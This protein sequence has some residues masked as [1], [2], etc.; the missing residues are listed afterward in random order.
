MSHANVLSDLMSDWSLHSSAANA[1]RRVGTD[2]LSSFYPVDYTY[3][4]NCTELQVIL[5]VNENN[6]IDHINDTEK[7]TH[8]K[9]VAP[10]ARIQL[11]TPFTEYK[12]RASNI[13]WEV[14]VRRKHIHLPTRTHG[15]R[16]L[17]VAHCMC[18]DDSMVLRYCCNACCVLLSCGVLV[19][20]SL[21][22]VMF[23]VIFH[24]LH[25]IH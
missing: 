16:H 14:Q 22:F 8:I 25:L 2:D 12:Q 18:C 10:D 1:A 3:E 7:N 4:V 5:N 19:C 21:S 20:M 23:V 6:I 13:T 9:L 15:C 11:H 17:E 24:F